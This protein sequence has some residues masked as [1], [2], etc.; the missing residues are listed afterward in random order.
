MAHP[1]VPM[2]SLASDLW[3]VVSLVDTW[4]L[5]GSQ[6]SSTDIEAFRQHAKN[7]LLDPDPFVGLSESERLQAQF[8]GNR[9]HYSKHLAGGVARTLAL[10]ATVGD[11]VQVGPGLTGAS[12]AS[13]IVRGLLDTT[14]FFAAWIDSANGISHSP[15]QSGHAPIVGRRH[16][17]CIIS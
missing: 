3:H 16:A 6:L 7:V 1:D 9:P 8:D 10:L 5:L 14:C 15:I 17:D 4:M 11:L 2:V 12:I 13:S